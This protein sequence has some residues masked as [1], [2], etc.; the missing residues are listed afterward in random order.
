MG[1]C[2]IFVPQC[3]ISHDEDALIDRSVRHLSHENNGE[4]YSLALNSSSGTNGQPS[5]P[6]LGFKTTLEGFKAYP[7]DD[8]P[9]PTSADY[10]L[11]TLLHI[12][13]PLASTV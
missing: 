4:S 10:A 12:A 2:T 6:T 3:R 9:G 8:D 13:S 1:A 5:T 7:E 11:E